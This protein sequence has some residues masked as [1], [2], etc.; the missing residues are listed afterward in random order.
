MNEPQEERAEETLMIWERPEP[1]SAPAPSPLSRERIVGAAIALAD[2]EGIAGVSLRKVGAAL[3]AGPMR[4]YGYL[5]TKEELLDLMVDAIYGRIASKTT[6][7]ENWREV[8]W[9]LAHL[10]RRAALRHPWFL[11]LMG[12]RPHIGP[13]ALAHLESSLAALS[14]A[15]GFEEIDSMMSAL[16]T[17]NAYVMG[18]LLSEASRLR[19]AALTGMDEQT[20]QLS[21]WPYMQRIIATGRFPMLT[22][23]VEDGHHPTADEAF[24][25]GLNAVLDGI[26]ARLR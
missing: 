12:G 20:W 25:D 22:R 10:K 24:D 6:P 3:D 11:E 1:V 18:T 7:N 19:S 26:S 4:L 23:F 9:S 16:R 8:L 17:V 2:R 14:A 21:S 15:P 5:S 13:N